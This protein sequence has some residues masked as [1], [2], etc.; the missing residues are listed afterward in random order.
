[1]KSNKQQQQQQQLIETKQNKS[2]D[3]NVVSSSFRSLIRDKSHKGVSFQKPQPISVYINNNKKT[4]Y[5]AVQRTRIVNYKDMPLPSLTNFRYLLYLN[6][7]SS[8][9]DPNYKFVDQFLKPR[10]MKQVA[11]GGNNEND[12][13]LVDFFSIHFQ[14]L[15]PA[16]LAYRE[17]ESCMDFYQFHIKDKLSVL[18]SD[19]VVVA[20][21]KDLVN[22]QHVKW[23]KQA[24]SKYEDAVYDDQDNFLGIM[25]RVV[26]YVRKGSKMTVQFQMA[27]NDKLF[28]KYAKNTA[29]A[30]LLR[31]PLI[32]TYEAHQDMSYNEFKLRLFKRCIFVAKNA[33]EA[34]NKKKQDR[35]KTL[36]LALMLQLF[37]N[38]IVNK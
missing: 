3:L 11:L 23:T 2:F 18:E 13:K 15:G 5:P 21:N 34:G 38:D 1:M 36:A 29:M 6:R 35:N 12:T 28:R 32:A 33:L 22:Q 8:F 4:K 14:K 30:R 19:P 37:G 7:K 16:V 17:V 24:I 20:E 25:T 26:P 10:S 31:R 27:N 9:W